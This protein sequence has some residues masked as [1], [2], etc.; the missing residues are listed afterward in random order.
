MPKRT[1]TLAVLSVGAVALA[2]TAY[3]IGSTSGNG[4]ATAASPKSSTQPQR[5][6][7]KTSASDPWVKSLADKLGVDPAK[8]ATALDAAR[9]AQKPPS[10]GPDDMLQKL[11]D[12][13]GVSKSDLQ[14]ALEKLR[15]TPPDPPSGKAPNPPNPPKFA[16]G[17]HPRMHF[18]SGGPGPGRPGRAF[19][20][21]FGPGG[22]S[23]QFASDLA[24]ALGIDKSKVTAAF[25][26]LAADRQA[27]E[28]ARWDTYVKALAD[29]LGLPVEKV[30][31]GLGSVPPR[32]FGGF[33][34]P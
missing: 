13:L 34:H 15:P 23:D 26:K 6:Q 19:G 1:K 2:S 8:L 11:A 22:I 9:D 20:F 4:S 24:K 12:E 16:P 10:G 31:Q 7:L 32:G 29:E 21:G 5:P 25:D 33:A 30:Q 18:R 17:A 14:K 28:Q 3:A 27:E